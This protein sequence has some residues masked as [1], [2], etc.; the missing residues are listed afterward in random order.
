MQFIQNLSNPNLIPS[1]EDYRLFA[2]ELFERKETIN[3]LKSRF[4]RVSGIY[5][6][7]KGKRLHYIG[8]SV[9]AYSRIY[10][11]RR[12]RE[13][14]FNA[15]SVVPVEPSA[16]PLVEFRLI[17]ELKPKGNTMH[18]SRRE[19]WGTITLDELA[20][21]LNVE[22]GVL[23]EVCDKNQIPLRNLNAEIKQ[24]LWHFGRR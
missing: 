15:M 9:N 10:T 20:I 21:V 4:P 5:G 3:V 1:P 18:V 19:S 14:Q 12:Y 7:I 13:G 8:R 2:A 23:V 22:P 6:L 16:L 17:R 24:V 11:H